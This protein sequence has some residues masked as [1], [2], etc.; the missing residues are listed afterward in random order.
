MS[1]KGVFKCISRTSQHPQCFSLRQP[2]N[3]TLF[4]SYFLISQLSGN[5]LLNTCKE[6]AIFTIFI[7]S[8]DLISPVFQFS[9][10]HSIASETILIRKPLK[11]IPLNLSGLLWHLNIWVLNSIWKYSAITSLNNIYLVLLWKSFTSNFLLYYIS[12]LF[13]I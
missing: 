9:F 4:D 10:R 13:L 1:S 6:M 5:S 7:S 11:C 3:L 8:S 12:I 2:H